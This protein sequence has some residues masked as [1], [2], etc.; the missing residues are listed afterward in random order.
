ME[1]EKK[2]E[3]V[4]ERDGRMVGHIKVVKTGEFDFN[5]FKSW[6]YETTATV[7]MDGWLCVFMCVPVC[8]CVCVCMCAQS[9]RAV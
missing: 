2:R 3:M 8:V 7:A 9:G 4:K 1:R 6:A 5:V